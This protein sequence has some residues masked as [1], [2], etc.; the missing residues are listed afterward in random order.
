MEFERALLE[1]MNY[2]KIME[3]LDDGDEESVK[4][5]RA[6]DKKELFSKELQDVCK[7]ILWDVD[8]MV[9]REPPLGQEP[10]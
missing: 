5:F 9:W 4:H 1:K 7:A 8:M 6:R 2:N 3:L 10:E